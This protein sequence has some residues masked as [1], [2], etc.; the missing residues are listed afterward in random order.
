VTIAEDISVMDDSEFPAKNKWRTERWAALAGAVIMTI[1]LPIAIDQGYFRYNAYVLPGLGLFSVFLYLGFAL[2]SKSALRFFKTRLERDKVAAIV[3]MLFLGAIIVSAVTYGFMKGIDASER[4]IAASK[5]SE[6]KAPPVPP[7]AG[8]SNSQGVSGRPSIDVQN[9]KEH[10]EPDSARKPTYTPN[11]PERESARLA[12]PTPAP[13]Q[14][15]VNA[16]NCPGGICPIGPINGNPTVN[17]FGVRQPLPTLTW[18]Q[19]QLDPN[20]SDIKFGGSPEPGQDKPGV[21]ANVR[22]NGYFSDPA[23]VVQCS[24]PCIASA[25]AAVGMVETRNFG[26]RGYADR[27]GILFISPSRLVAGDSVTIV[28][29][30]TDDRSVTL[31]TVEPYAFSDQK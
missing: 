21:L 12:A 10:T 6:A 9:H 8:L 1:G 11:K 28:F 19:S 18:T 5:E 22:V 13:D 25:G 23:F 16:P 29:R 7:V 3:V 26:A 27:A 4:H 17:N 24:V 15:V 30:S 20:Q 31:K 2:T 14:P